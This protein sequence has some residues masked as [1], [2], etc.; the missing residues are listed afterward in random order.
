MFA[1]STLTED[2]SALL[3]GEVATEFQDIELVLDG[4]TIKAHKVTLGLRKQLA[5]IY[6]RLVATSI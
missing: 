4:K 3:R 1:A 2:M 5:A 6:V